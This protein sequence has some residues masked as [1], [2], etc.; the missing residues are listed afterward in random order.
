MSLFFLRG[1]VVSDLLLFIA[2]QVANKGCDFGKILSKTFLKDI[3]A[4]LVIIMSIPT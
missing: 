3:L 2:R 1:F 4:Y